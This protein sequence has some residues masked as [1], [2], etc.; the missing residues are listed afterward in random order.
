[1]ILG[2]AGGMSWK[3]D[4]ANGERRCGRQGIADTH[5]SFLLQWVSKIPQDSK[6][7]KDSKFHWLGI[8][9]LNDVS[10][11]RHV[12]GVNVMISVRWELRSTAFSAAFHLLRQC[13]GCCRS[14]RL[15]R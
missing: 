8:Y 2:V 5:R 10:I 11:Q 4:P 15:H 14:I 1:V 6:I 3:G 9:T 7:P 12:A 13:G